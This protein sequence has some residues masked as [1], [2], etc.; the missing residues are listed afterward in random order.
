LYLAPALRTLESRHASDRLMQR[1]GRAAAEWAE[2]L[3]TGNGS[4][5]VIVGPGNNGGDALVAARLLRQRFFA[6]TVVFAGDASRLPVDA[7]AAWRDFAA[8]GGSVVDEIPAQGP[9]SLIIDGLFGIG[10]ARPPTGRYA[11]L[12]AAINQIAGRER[13]PVLALDCPSGLDAERGALLGSVQGSAVRATHTLTFIAGKPG[14]LTA[15]GPDHC[16][17]IRIDRL[18]LDPPAELPPA[19]R[20]LS[21]AAFADCLAPRRRNTHKGSFGSVGVIGGAPTMVGALFLAARAALKLGAGLVYAGP[22]D[23]EARSFD[24]QQPELLLRRPQTLLQAPLG[25]LACGPGLGISVEASEL[26]ETALALDLPLLLD[27]DALNLVASEKSLQQALTSRRTPAILTPHPAE[28]GRLLEVSSA[29]IQANRLEAARELA[30][31]YR[32]HV[33]LKGCGTVVAACDGQW[34][35]NTTGNPGMATA[36]MGDVLSG[37]ILALLGQGWPGVP[38]LLA[39]VH[40]HG[41]AAD[42]LVASGVGPVGLTAGEV[43][44]AARRLFNQWLR[45]AG[46]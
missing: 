29:E 38:A 26:M 8:A 12:I 16:G 3:A 9:W 21:L 13:C 33:A 23:A 24:P 39:G 6:V 44:D 4:I 31:R 18:D 2:E 1:A 15:D 14:L 42:H 27:A 46:R 45:E 22:L 28:A 36:G 7:A 35:I 10:L 11:A 43:I 34:W 17:Q 19:G 5:L 25:A 30:S 20:R 37:L 40:L 41:A 32:S